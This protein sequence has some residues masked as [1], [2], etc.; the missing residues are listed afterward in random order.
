MQY[1]F[2]SFGYKYFRDETTGLIKHKNAMLIQQS[3]Y[4][5]RDYERTFGIVGC[6]YYVRDI[7]DDN[8]KWVDYDERKGG[9][10]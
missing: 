9:I 3:D 7:T 5:G 1:Q 10:L 8:F 4:N 2:S 6:Y